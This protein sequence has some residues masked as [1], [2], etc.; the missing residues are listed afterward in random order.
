MVSE[1]T[2]S[3]FNDSKVHDSPIQRFAIGDSRFDNL[4]PGDQTIGTLG[5]SLRGRPGETAA[6][7]AKRTE[8][9]EPDYSRFTRT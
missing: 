7:R 5:N 1:S 9:R 6:K 2:D 4:R 3:S 8:G